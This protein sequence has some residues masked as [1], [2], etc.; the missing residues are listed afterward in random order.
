MKTKKLRLNAEIRKGIS[1]QFKKHLENENTQER[2]AFLQS[3][4][5]YPNA[6]NEAFEVIKNI[7]GKRFPKE[8]IDMQKYLDDKH[9]LDNHRLDNCFNVKWV[10][11]VKETRYNSHTQQQEVIEV[12]KEQTK[13]FD[14]SLNASVEGINES[15]GALPFSYAMFREDLLEK[16]CNPDIVAQTLEKE[17]SPHRKIAISKCNDF[18]RDEKFTDE[19]G[20]SKSILERGSEKFN[21]DVLGSRYC[22]TRHF[23]ISP[24]E[25]QILNNWQQ[26]KQIVCLKHFEF[27]KSIQDQMNAINSALK[28]YQYFDQAKELAS[29]VGLNLEE[30]DKVSS[31]ALTLYNPQSVAESLKSMKNKK[32]SREDKIKARLL[33]ERESASQSLN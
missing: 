2:E 24:S 12:E 3:R 8:D 19:N 23:D 6:E 29:T 13:N 31:N 9:N 33:Y 21:L 11:L 27:V 5:R 22:H 25:L 15:G 10:G 1:H 18:L 16:N 14:F 7:V 28:S 17:D 32:I 30:I 4:E 26:A 20:E